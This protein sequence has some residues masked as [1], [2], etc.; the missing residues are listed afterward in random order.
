MCKANNQSKPFKALTKRE[1]EVLKL[2]IKG[3]TN[4]QIAD[5]LIISENTVK[6]HI[7]KLMTKFQSSNRVEIVVK[8]IKNG[9]VRV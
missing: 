5:L 6:A 7:G 8:A 3:K 1:Y 2:I 4:P 9:L